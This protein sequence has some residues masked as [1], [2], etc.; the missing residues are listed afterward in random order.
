MNVPYFGTF[1]KTQTLPHSYEL[2]AMTM[3]ENM[4][5]NTRVKMKALKSHDMRIVRNE[6]TKQKWY[7][8]K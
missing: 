8:P 1:C 3:Y 6:K 4:L 2:W 5:I 7:I